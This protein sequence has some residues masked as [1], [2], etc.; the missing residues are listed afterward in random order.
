MFLI[1]TDRQDSSWLTLALE[2]G[3][4]VC[5]F[6]LGSRLMR[7][8]KISCPLLVSLGLF[9]FSMLLPISLYVLGFTN[10]YLWFSSLAVIFGAGLVTS[11]SPCTL[12]VLPLTLGYIGKYIALFK[13]I[14]G[15]ARIDHH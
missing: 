11:L 2:T 12:S 3:L 5:C 14:V 15:M 13:M 4:G 1:S 10:L 9:S 7:L 6:Q 8:S